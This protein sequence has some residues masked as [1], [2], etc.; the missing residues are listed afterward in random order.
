MIDEK[1]VNIPYISSVRAITQLLQSVD[2]RNM[3]ERRPHTA[4]LQNFQNRAK[5][6]TLWEIQ[7]AKN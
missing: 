5:E 3:I 7:N 1:P 4:G 2:W 6:D